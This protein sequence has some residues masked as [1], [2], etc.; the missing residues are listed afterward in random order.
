MNPVFLKNMAALWRTDPRMA[1]RID[2][3]PA[4]AGVPVEASKSGPM[5]ARMETDGAVWARCVEAHREDDRG[6]AQPL[7]TSHV[8]AGMV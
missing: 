2:D 6:R 4:D 7:K 5:T 8:E 1:Q 3:L